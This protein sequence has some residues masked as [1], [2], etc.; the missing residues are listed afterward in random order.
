[1]T[2]AAQA[3]SA[4][5]TASNDLLQLSGDMFG[6]NFQTQM[7]RSSTFPLGDQK[8]DAWGQQNSKLLSVNIHIDNLCNKGMLWRSMHCQRPY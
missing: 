1:M 7:T 8:Q 6:D 3:P 5:P 4:Q 2:Q